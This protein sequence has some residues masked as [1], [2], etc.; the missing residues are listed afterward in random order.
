MQVIG[1]LQINSNTPI[2][3]LEIDNA[4]AETVLINCFKQLRLKVTEQHSCEYILKNAALFLPVLHT[5]VH[6]LLTKDNATAL[7]TK[8]LL[9]VLINLLS[10]SDEQEQGQRSILMQKHIASNKL[11]A[12]FCHADGCFYEV[13]ALLYNVYRCNC[14]QIHDLALISSILLHDVDPNTSNEY[15]GFLVELIMSQSHVW[16]NY[17]QLGHQAKLVLQDSLRNSFFADKSTATIPEECLKCLCHAFK[18]SIDVV[19][20]VSKESMQIFGNLVLVIAKKISVS[21]DL[22]AIREVALVLE[23]L[24][25][26]AS[27]EKCLLVLQHDKDLLVNAGVLLI[28]VHR[29]GKRPNNV[30][31]PLQKLCTIQDDESLRSPTTGFKADLIR[32]VG[33]LCWKNKQMQDLVSV[34]SLSAAILTTIFLGKRGRID[35]GVIRLLQY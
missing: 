22:S 35:S 32:L 31:T 34:G 11:Q 26:A 10:C 33:N 19:F 7:Y 5:L 13:S 25:H 4:S 3:V 16:D 12:F 2:T 18:T 14:S 9:H 21:D 27:V 29:L 6:Y 1:E 20:Q 24:G 17:S 30:F 23:N 8:Y 15:T 28:N